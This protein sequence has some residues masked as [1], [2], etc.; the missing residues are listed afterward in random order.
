MNEQ[1]YLKT[2]ID[3]QI[4]WYSKKATTNKNLHHWTKALVIIFSAIIPLIAGIEFDA[5]KKNITLGLFGTLI[6]ILSGLSGLLKFQEKWS[7]YRT[8]SETLKHEKILF[9]TSTGPFD[10]QVEP[11][12]ILVTTIENLISKEHS[13]W[14]QYI[15]KKK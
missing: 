15:N 8:T 4:N 12:K 6:A 14:S 1:E 10:N 2:R 11:F 13:A 3:D 5:T 7:E 9:Q